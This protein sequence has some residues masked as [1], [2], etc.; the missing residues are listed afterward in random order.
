[1]KNRQLIKTL[2]VPYLHVDTVC[3]T[4]AF[5]CAV[6]EIICMIFLDDL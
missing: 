5:T 3:F 1:M 4:I 6:I 2:I